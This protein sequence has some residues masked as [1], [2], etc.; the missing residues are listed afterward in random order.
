MRISNRMGGVR[1]MAMA[2][3]VSFAVASLGTLT[4]GPLLLANLRLSPTLP[5][6]V[7]VEGLVL[8]AIW[9]WLSGRGWPRRWAEPRR[10]LLRSRVVPLPAFGWAAVAGGLSLV[11]L[12]G[13]WIVLV[14]MT[15]AGGN[16]TLPNAAAYPAVVIVAV[17]AMGSL[18]SPLSEEAAFRGYGQVLLERRFS[19]VVAVA[20]SSL[21]FALYH[22]PTQ[23]FAPSKLLFYFTV[24]VVFGTIARLTGSVLPALPVH[25]AGDVLF[26]TAIW[27]HDAGRT[28]IWTH[29]A[30]ATFWLD[31]AL[32]VVFGG[33][34]LLAFRR[35]RATTRDA[36][37]S[38][39]SPSPTRPDQ[40]PR[41][42]RSGGEA[43]SLCGPGQ[44]TLSSSTSS[45]ARAS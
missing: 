28:L 13:L 19:P 4:W 24:G 2:G 37:P 29:G 25:I 42:Q 45:T 33:L 23:G 43:G 31:V 35:L 14:R 6:A 9:A 40:T 8:I 39:G 27:P 7:A 26:F 12:V 16:P 44:A 21:F 38:P 15:G 30:D 3:L 1:T 11:A 22:G 10:R 34:A 17:I 32:V 18:V 20:F 36:R 5:W 41:H